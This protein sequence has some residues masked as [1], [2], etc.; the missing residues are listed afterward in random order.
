[1]RTALPIA[2]A[3]LALACSGDDEPTST[4]TQA[5]RTPTAIVEATAS[6]IAQATPDATATPVPTA[7]RATTTTSTAIPEVDAVIEAFL[8]RDRDQIL[9]LLRFTEAPCTHA[10]G[11]GGEP[12]CF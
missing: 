5:P 12:K 11:L 4:P 1:M 3:F 6:A 7:T 8:S 2:L 10:F 9:S